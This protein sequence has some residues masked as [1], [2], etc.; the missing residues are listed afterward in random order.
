M[1]VCSAWLARR[2]PPRLGAC[3]RRRATQARR[4]RRRIDALVPASMRQ[5]YDV[6]GVI[7]AIARRG[8]RL[9]VQA[10]TLP[11]TSSPRWSGSTADRCVVAPLI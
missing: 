8:L 2:S 3:D 6:L 5:A 1:A 4:G 9:R 11:K 7:V 10:A